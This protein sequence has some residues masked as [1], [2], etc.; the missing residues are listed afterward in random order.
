MRD[1]PAG[2]REHDLRLVLAE[3]WRIDAAALRYAAVGGGSYHW[4][5]RDRSGRRWFVTV[6]DLDD[7]AWLGHTRPAVMAGLRSAMETALVLRR[8][9][10]L[11]FVVAPVPGLDGAAVRPAGPGHAVAVFPF[12]RGTP[13]RFD[14]ALPAAERAALTDMLAT[15][16]QSARVGAPV[17]AI[18]LARRADL[19]AG[20]RDLGRPWRAGPFGEQARTLLAGA[21]DRI[22][23]LLEAFDRRAGTIRADDFVITHGEPHPGNVMR[24]GP[25]RML[26]DWDTVGLGPPERDLWMVAGESGEEA[27]RYAGLTG[28]AVDPGLLEWY[29]L[30]WALDDISA[31]AYRLRCAHGRTADAEHAWVAL[32]QTVASLGGRAAARVI[33]C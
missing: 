16:H 12:L 23:R 6:D 22:H 3:G 18:G 19:D 33:N 31:F 11:D 29:R 15:L 14:E 10:G 2:L 9:V 1:R 32:E 25:R 27:R 24:A 4:A 13:G 17:A 8:D 20:L 28:R 26:I 21:C 30:R 7:K 5:A